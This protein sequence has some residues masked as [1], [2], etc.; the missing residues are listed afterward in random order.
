MLAECI[1]SYQRDKRFC[2]ALNLQ[3]KVLRTQ[4]HLLVSVKI[5]PALQSKSL[6][7]PQRSDALQYA[8]SSKAVV[9]GCSAHIFSLYCSNTTSLKQGNG[10]LK[11]ESFAAE[12]FRHII[13]YPIFN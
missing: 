10:L 12:K 1:D 3:N 2:L 11:S 7:T 4:M 9:D 8:P 5:E 13:S 6:V